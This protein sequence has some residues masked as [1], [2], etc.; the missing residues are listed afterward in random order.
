MPLAAG[1]A[2]AFL[3]EAAALV[4]GG[5]LVAYVA[6]RMGLVPIVGFLLTGVLIGPSALGIVQTT[7]L[8]DAA[9]EIGVILL[10][11]TI[12]LEFS[13]ERLA[14]LTR[15]IFGGGGLQVLLA[16][17]LSTGVLVLA[18]VDASTALYT[19]LL[20]S[21]SS[22]AIVL[23]LLGERLEV[24]ARHGQV[25]LGV[26][27]FQD[28]AIVVMVLLVPVL[29]DGG[30]G[31]GE[32]GVALLKAAGI[33]AA[34]V[35]VARR[36]MPI[37]LERVARTCSPE[38][39]L[40]TVVAVALG[41]AYAT[42]LAGVSVSLGAFLGGLLVSESRF[43]RQALAEV[44]PLQIV[45]SAMFFVSVGL[46]LDLGFLAT[47]LPVVL[48]AALAVLVLKAVT[49]G[50]AVRALGER[51]GVAVAAGLMLAQVGEFSFVLER[52]GRE[53]GLTPAGLGDDGSQGFIAV[54]VLLMVATP[55]LTGAGVALGRRLEDREERE[56]R[57]RGVPEPRGSVDD[58]L[59]GHVLISGYG[60]W[61]RQLA[62]VL[63]RSG[64]PTAIVTLSPDGASEAQ[65]RGL[66]V[67]LGDSTKQLTLREAGLR[68]ASYLVVLDDEPEQA[69]RI[70]AAAKSVNPH[71]KVLVRRHEPGPVGDADYVVS[72][73][74]EASVR[75]A[76]KLLTAYDV[77]GE[78]RETARVALR[79]AAPDNL[80]RGRTVVDTTALV[81]P[82]LAPDGCAHVADTRA[83]LPSAP[84][85]EDCLREGRTDWVHLRVCLHCGHV[86][87]CDSSPRRHGREHAHVRDHPVIRSAEPGEAWSWCF[88]DE[89]MLPR[90]EERATA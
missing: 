20:V 33:I 62:G 72:E 14:R 77:A 2:P 3:G 66:P 55:W 44:L 35:L 86:G 16:T 89:R 48:G 25:G 31:L 58:E 88:E 79:A 73:E 9:A 41:T 26:L 34:V 60:P 80:P 75:F 10:L 18:G 15:L 70:A 7:E 76:D 53:A 22:T 42:S 83:V 11:F 78:H 61:G 57:E 84:G 27:L 64:V 49:T 45:F 37:L 29:G 67:L 12:G 21:L 47:H 19:G 38:V 68:R 46:L 59:D 4:V 30:G 13:L 82:D 39:F 85:C 43:D 50:V 28:L 24:G 23:K 65:A 40:L 8:A 51:P 63:Q 74:A 5:A 69:A 81:E 56:V 90:V 71:A 52:V 6:F 54:T 36:L 1:E 87:C 32:V 17:G